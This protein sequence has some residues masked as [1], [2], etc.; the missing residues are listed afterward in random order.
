MLEHQ[1]LVIDNVSG[2]KYLFRK[3]LIKS[4]KW[5]K[6]EEINEL[7]SWVITK[8]GNMHKAIIKDVFMLLAV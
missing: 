1:K 3:E 5:L 2:N 6:P 8:Y 7:Q 4:L